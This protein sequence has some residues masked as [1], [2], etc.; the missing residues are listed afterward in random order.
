MITIGLPIIISYYAID[1]MNISENDGVI[2]KSSIKYYPKEILKIMGTKGQ[3]INN[4]HKEPHLK[5]LKRFDANHTYEK[6]HYF[7]K[8]FI[9]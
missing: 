6:I 4:A 2:C 9:N 1:R 5:Y 8:S 3:K 7:I